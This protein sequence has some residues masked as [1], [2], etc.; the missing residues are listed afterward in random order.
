MNQ[1]R[2]LYIVG[3]IAGYSA[4]AAAWLNLAKDVIGLVGV[5]AGAALS[6]WALWDRYKKH[7]RGE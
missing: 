2:N 4:G 1:D 3:Q 6:L 7:K 5:S